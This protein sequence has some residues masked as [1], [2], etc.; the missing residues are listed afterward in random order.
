MSANVRHRSLLFWAVAVLVAAGA[1]ALAFRGVNWAELLAT[2][3]R[4]R[5]LYLALACLV[6]TGSY[7]IR[8][9]RWRV[10]LSA[11]KLIP[12]RTV[13]WANM[14]GYLGNS[15]LPARAGELIRSAVL[16]KRAGIS[17]S[18]VFATA[19]TERIMDAVALVLISLM[20]MLT[21]RDLPEWLISATRIMAVLGGASL[22]VLFVAARSQALGAALLRRLPLPAALRLRVLSIAE[23]F[24]LGARAIYHPS[25]AFSFIGLAAAIW[26][27]DACS[28]IIAARAL[29]LAL[30]LP[31]ALVL[32]AAL[33]LASAVPS[34]PGYVGIYQLVAV[35]ILM[36]FGYSRDAALAFILV[37]QACS[38]VVISLW[39][40][41]GLWRLGAASGPLRSA[42]SLP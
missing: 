42:Q 3:G 23:Q 11:E 1:L 20:A 4:A 5:L 10:L 40:V 22:L 39:G 9:L 18:F 41:I 12:L 34:T 2:L 8:G 17:T 35:T 14:V 6:A 26:L 29:S 13:F 19:V 37:I 16:G 33:G 30:S 36:P 27:M 32:L 21:M 25:R 28:S 15:F 38:Y 7:C 24:L 31:Q